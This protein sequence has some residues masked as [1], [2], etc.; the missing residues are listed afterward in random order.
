MAG[1]VP[2]VE[3]R[4]PPHKNPHPIPK[5]KITLQKKL[6]AKSRNEA[7]TGNF[8]Q[9]I[10]AA[11]SIH[12]FLPFFIP[13]PQGRMYP[14]SPMLKTWK[15]LRSFWRE[16]YSGNCVRAINKEIPEQFFMAFA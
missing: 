11:F 14:F 16:Y 3:G 15:S 12:K 5:Y 10:R 8:A 13:P 6:E 2:R 1:I 7:H 4:F 9:L